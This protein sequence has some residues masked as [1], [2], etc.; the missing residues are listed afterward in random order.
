MIFNCA[1]QSTIAVRSDSSP[2]STAELTHGS[3]GNNATLKK[4]HREH[5]PLTNE[6]SSFCPDW[7][8]VFQWDLPFLVLVAAYCN[9]SPGSWKKKNNIDTVTH[10]EL[11]TLI[12]KNTVI[13][14]LAFS[15]VSP[16]RDAATLHKLLLDSWDRKRASCCSF[17]TGST[18]FDGLTDCI[19]SRGGS[20]SGCPTSVSL[21][22][23]DTKP[24]S[25]GTC[26]LYDGGSVILASSVQVQGG[27]RD[28]SAR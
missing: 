17:A 22:C 15:K 16:K 9:K 2:D 7:C 24:F 25:I 14:R 6:W 8:D 11:V 1:K 4:T 3:L 28:L 27:G 21:C 13:H 19:C 23:S 12:P 10:I 5:I 18:G 20:R 26:S